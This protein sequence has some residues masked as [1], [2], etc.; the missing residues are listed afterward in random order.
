[1]NIKM[2]GKDRELGNYFDHDNSVHLSLH[3][4]SSRMYSLL[5]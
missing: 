4:T 3:K 5:N 1:M 2:K